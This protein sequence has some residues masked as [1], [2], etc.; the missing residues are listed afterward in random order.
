[1]KRNVIVAGGGT[2]G[3]IYPGIA[4]AKA[5]MAV[6]P[7]IQVHFVGTEE[8]LEARIIP[9]EG[10]QLHFIQGGKL[11]FR[12]SPFKKILTLLKL[13]IGFF[14]SLFLL[15]ELKPLVVVG[16]GGYASAPMTLV[17]SLIGI[18]TAIWEPN[19]LPGMANRILSKFVRNAFVVFPEAK[20]RLTSET[21]EV[22]GMPIRKEMEG[23]SQKSRN[24]NEF[25]ILHYGGSQGSR[26][27]GT[28]L[29][30]A[31]KKGGA[32]LE[33]VKIV[34]QTGSLDFQKF[35]EAYRGL[36]NIVDVREFIFDMPN[37]YEWADI[38]IVRGG[39]STLTELAA[40][41]LPAIVIPL[42]AADGHQQKNAESLVSAKAATMLLQE[43]LT[44]D[45]LIEEILKLKNSAQLRATY[46]QNIINFHVPQ[47]A[48]RI[49]QRLIELSEL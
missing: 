33:N 49:A 13:P 18:P 5:M 37:F 21:V 30:E 12:G 20:G 29:C 31:V 15:W 10:F 44:A 4:I 9:R 32:W 41:R 35:K 19:A 26:A 17:A 40:Y 25:H 1:M 7:E 11:N 27:I 38:A 22:V 2:G 43:N 3:H 24:E 28:A 8:G 34:H 14:Q 42:P 6:D 36:E 16:V 48:D 23:R 47:A 39:A 45:T 46:A